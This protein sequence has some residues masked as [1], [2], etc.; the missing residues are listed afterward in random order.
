MVTGNAITGEARVDL[1][2]P[3][4]E[5][6]VQIANFHRLYAR[7]NVSEEPFVPLDRFPLVRQETCNS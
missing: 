2:R 3:L 1:N 4:K 6:V 5:I 7:F